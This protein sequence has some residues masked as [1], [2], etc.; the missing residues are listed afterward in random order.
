M[1]TMLLGIGALLLATICIALSIWLMFIF[2]RWFAI[3]LVKTKELRRTWRPN[4]KIEVTIRWEMPSDLFHL[5]VRKKRWRLFK[6][7]GWKYVNLYAGGDTSL[8][9]DQDTDP[10]FN[11]IH[12][13][14]VPGTFNQFK[15]Y[16]LLRS[17]IH[18]YG[19]LA[20]YYDLRIG[21]YKEDKKKFSFKD[22]CKEL[23]KKSETPETNTVNA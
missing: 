9:P 13:T 7:K 19:D 8:K 17:L 15:E 10:E 6:D 21:Q 3:Q 1:K 22:W 11:W 20:G 5:M 12:I 4:Q 14:W 16:D 2:M 23:S 18:T